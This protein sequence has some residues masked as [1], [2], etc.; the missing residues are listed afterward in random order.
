MKTTL[1]FKSII[2]VALILM[3]VATLKAQV[4]FGV[5]GGINESTISAVGDIYGNQDYRPG[6]NI[7]GTIN[8]HFS[9]NVTAQFEVIYSQKGKKIKTYFNDQDHNLSTKCNY[10]SIPL[11]VRG[12]TQVNENRTRVYGETG[13]YYGYLINND[14]FSNS[15]SGNGKKF[16]NNDYGIVFG[17]GIIKP[18]NNL[19]LVIGFRYEMGLAKMYKMDNDIRNKSLSL[20]IEVQF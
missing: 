1:Q 8:Y 10:L 16:F 13:A 20:N 3:C 17:G 2:T 14:N 11:I 9:D 6:F 19:N 18:I 12:S 15:L 5:K 7:G 4:S